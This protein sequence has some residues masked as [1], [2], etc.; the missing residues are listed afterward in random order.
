MA[1]IS[2]RRCK[3]EGSC[4]RYSDK[5][6]DADF[7]ILYSEALNPQEIQETLILEFI[8]VK[9]SPRKKTRKIEWQDIG[10]RWFGCSFGIA[11]PEKEHPSNLKE[12]KIKRFP[13][14]NY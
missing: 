12:W 11:Y 14:Q 10:A 3:Y 13:P 2:L 7:L 1:L 6:P 9:S 8:D 5:I 4:R